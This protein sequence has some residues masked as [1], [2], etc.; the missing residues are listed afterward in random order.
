MKYCMLL[1]WMMA[2]NLYALDEYKQVPFD[3]T[4]LDLSK[5]TKR[6]WSID[7]TMFPAS[8]SGK[9]TL[10]VIPKSKG[11]NILGEPRETVIQTK[12][13]Y[14]PKI[15]RT[16]WELKAITLMMGNYSKGKYESIN[17]AILKKYKALKSISKSDIDKFNK[18]LINSLSSYYENGGVVLRIGR[19]TAGTFMT[20]DYYGNDFAKN[21]NKSISKAKDDG[22]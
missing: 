3:K 2:F 9:L 4:S 19:D 16:S 5:Q 1:T 22:L 17:S 20:L 11:F 12:E 13:S 8:S 15:E 14:N 7:F 21:I 18:R 10:F 6:N